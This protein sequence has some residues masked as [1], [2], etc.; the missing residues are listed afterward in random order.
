MQLDVIY[1]ITGL[2]R[3]DGNCIVLGQDQSNQGYILFVADSVL[4]ISKIDLDR[5]ASAL[6]FFKEKKVSPLSNPKQVVELEDEILILTYGCLHTPYYKEGVNFCF[7][8]TKTSY[9][10]TFLGEEYYPPSLIISMLDVEW[11]IKK[12]KKRK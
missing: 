5:L 6:E 11:C 12:I 10:T 2:G 9:L 7:N 1:T 3:D 4:K 8:Q